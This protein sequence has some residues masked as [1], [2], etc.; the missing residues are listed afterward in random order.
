MNWVKE[1]R[2][3]TGYSQEQLA[4]Y[5]GVSKS[6]IYHAEKNN[7]SLPI[8][9]MAKLAEL[10]KRLNDPISTETG[11]DA[12]VIMQNGIEHAVLL[13]KQKKDLLLISLEKLNKKMKTA[14]SDIQKDLS[15]LKANASYP[16]TLK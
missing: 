15:A 9:P 7:R 13:A 11:Q 4:G 14:I 10:Y 16:G 6:L 3:K 8:F 5:L 12:G 1:V 2:D